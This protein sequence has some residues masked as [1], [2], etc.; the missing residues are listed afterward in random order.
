MKLQVAVGRGGNRRPEGALCCCHAVGST[1]ISFTA[2]LQKSAANV[3]SNFSL[4]DSTNKKKERL[5]ESKLLQLVC[6][7]LQAEIKIERE[8]GM[9]VDTH[10]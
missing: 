2:S 4:I 8:R 10:S 7:S 6:R 1:Y 5:P 9:H 3:R